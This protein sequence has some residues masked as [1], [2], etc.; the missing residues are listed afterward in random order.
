MADHSKLDAADVAFKKIQRAEEG[1]KAMSDYES[2]G[3][4]IRAKTAR[5]KALRLARDAAVPIAPDKDKKPAR[6]KK[7]TAKQENET[8][9]NLSDW[10]DDQQKG[11]R[12][13]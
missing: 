11:G 4:A 10:M 5:L 6:A 3:A 7:T 12:N 1:K 13:I 8:S 9:A 2:Q